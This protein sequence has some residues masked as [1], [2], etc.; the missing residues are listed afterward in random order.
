MMFGLENDLLVA[1][2]KSACDSALLFPEIV[3]G[4]PIHQSHHAKIIEQI[5]QDAKENDWSPVIATH[6]EMMILWI[7]HQIRNKK[8]TPEEVWVQWID[9]DKT[10]TLRMD[11]EGDFIDRW[12]HGFFEERA[13]FLFD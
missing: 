11:I 5:V 4:K 10:F 3:R 7:S 13:R 2:A 12:P 9:P 1:T 6:S 8:M